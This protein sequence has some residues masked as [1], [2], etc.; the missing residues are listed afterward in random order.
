M[1]R[2]GCQKYIT[3]TYQRGLNSQGTLLLPATIIENINLGK[4]SI[5]QRTISVVHKITNSKYLK[6]LGSAKKL[7]NSLVKESQVQ[8]AD[9]AYIAVSY[10]DKKKVNKIIQLY[11]RVPT[12]LKEHTVI[13]EKSVSKQ[14]E[15]GMWRVLGMI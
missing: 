15:S 10:I 14:Y 2:G 9:V 13:L 12:H 8:L 5:L 1:L 7:C 6:D 11:M 3:R 4:Y